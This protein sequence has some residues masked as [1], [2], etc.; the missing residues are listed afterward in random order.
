MGVLIRPIPPLEFKSQWY[1]YNIQFLISTRALGLSSNHVEIKK[2]STTPQYRLWAGNPHVRF[3]KNTHY[4]INII[5]GYTRGKG[6]Q[7]LPT[8]FMDDQPIVYMTCIK[9]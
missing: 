3:A 6:G 2:G 4:Y 9:Y 1:T 8:W 5:K 7:K